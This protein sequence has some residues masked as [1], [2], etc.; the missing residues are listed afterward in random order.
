MALTVTDRL[1]RSLAT[2]HVA[3]A[4]G[5]ADADGWRV[6]WLPGRALTRVQ[7]IA[8]MELAEMAEMA[9]E[10]QDDCDPGVYDETYWSRADDHAG[11]LGLNGPAAIALI[12]EAGNGDGLGRNSPGQFGPPTPEC[13]RSALWCR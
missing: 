11:Q 1:V 6:T 8:A 4:A 7:A 5:Q 13:Q 3:E 2:G 9:A 10:A 12:L